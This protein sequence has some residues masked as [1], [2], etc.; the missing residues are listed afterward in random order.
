MSIVNLKGLAVSEN[1]YRRARQIVEEKQKPE[2]GRK[3]ANEVLSSLRNMMPGWTITTNARDWG[4]GMRN[5][6]ISESILDRM[7][8]DPEAMVRFKA[9]I[10]D[11]EDKVPE[12]EE[13][14]Q[15]NYGRTLEFGITW[16]PDG[17][18]TRAM[19]IVRTLMGADIRTNFELS[20]SDTTTWADMIR[21]KLEALSEGQVQDADGSRSWIG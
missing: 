16:D 9:L 6:E 8:E 11:L 2:G 7:A 12:L 1:S 20:N 13:W 15:Q 10:L 14:A 3:S 19:G 17:S 4:N 5:I 18:S 21:Q